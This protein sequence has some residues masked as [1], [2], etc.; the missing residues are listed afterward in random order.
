M[1]VQNPCTTFVFYSPKFQFHAFGALGGV[2]TQ[3]FVF[4]WVE[5]WK[6]LNSFEKDPEQTCPFYRTAAGSRKYCI[7]V[8]L[9]QFCFTM[10][11]KVVM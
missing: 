4:A 6:I 2:D 7:K 5:R 10:N 1:R 11:L 3:L 9:H 8:V